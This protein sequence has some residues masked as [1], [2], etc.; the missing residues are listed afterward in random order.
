MVDLHNV[1]SINLKG[2]EIN[3][4]NT[5]IT[6][7]GPA[8]SIPTSNSVYNAI[9]A[10]SQSDTSTGVMNN[11]MHVYSDELYYGISNPLAPTSGYKFFNLL[12]AS[13]NT[14]EGVNEKNYDNNPYTLL[15][16]G[17]H[18]IDDWGV[19]CYS[20]SEDIIL[21]KQF[22]LV[23]VIT[24][25]C[26]IKNI[27]SI[28]FAASVPTASMKRI[29]APGAKT[30]NIASTLSSRDIEI[31]FN[32][33]FTS[34]IEVFVNPDTKVTFGENITAI[35]LP[36]SENI[37]ELVIKSSQIVFI[38]SFKPNTIKKFHPPHNNCFLQRPSIIDITVGEPDCEM[39]ISDD[40]NF[41]MNPDIV[42]GPN[43]LKRII[44]PNGKYVRAFQVD[45][46]EGYEN[47]PMTQKVEFWKNTDDVY[48][49]ELNSKYRF[50]LNKLLDMD[51]IKE[52]Q[53]FSYSYKNTINIPSEMRSNSGPIRLSNLDTTTP[54]ITIPSAFHRGQYTHPVTSF[55]F[56]EPTTLDGIKFNQNLKEIYI[57]N[58]I[59]TSV[60]HV[61][62][63]NTPNYSLTKLVLSPVTKE[64][65]TS[66]CVKNAKQLR[67]FIIPD[68]VTKVGYGAFVNQSF[69]SL[70]L[71]SSITNASNYGY[72][73]FSDPDSL[74]EVKYP[75][76]FTSLTTSSYAAAG[77]FGMTASSQFDNFLSKLVP[78]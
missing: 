43:A 63:S 12:S 60:G 27:A 9:I 17:Q 51:M 39:Y 58:T 64:L 45:L 73:A 40:S 22:V 4:V 57:T 52:Y 41:F 47:P 56:V 31:D 15:T 78:Y 1:N 21:P 61:F 33:P 34:G 67:S 50:E 54:Y 68:S 2:F 19:V 8:D 37:R 20:A 77:M 44:N 66:D 69:E 75:S 72:P 42:C 70:R 24:K 49:D 3:S 55:D 46:S 62:N 30:F 18:D 14:A 7:L 6:G 48:G 59:V 53:R 13:Y 65:N 74:A 36:E 35:S 29:V 71:P 32:G 38:N 16:T 26:T 10:L 5:S 11:M 23:D 76:A 25:S 28:E